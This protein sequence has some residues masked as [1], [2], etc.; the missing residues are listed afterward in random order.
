VCPK[1]LPLSIRKRFGKEIAD[2][3]GHGR[4]GMLI[5][6]TSFKSGSRCLQQFV[7]P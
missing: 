5:T 3:W 1:D 7:N 6:K 2:C 4:R